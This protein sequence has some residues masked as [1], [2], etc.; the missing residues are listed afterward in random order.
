M[1]GVCEGECIGRRSGDE[2]LTLTR[3]N[4][5]ELPQLYEPLE[6]WKSVL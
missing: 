6:G 1:T 5:C 2:L 3:C 4:I